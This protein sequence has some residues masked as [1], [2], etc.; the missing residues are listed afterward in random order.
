MARVQ[1]NCTGCVPIDASIIEVYTQLISTE[2]RAEEAAERA[3]H[4]AEHA[5]GKSPYIGENGDWWE[6]NDEQAAFIDTGVQ[7]QGQVA[8]DIEM[9]TTSTNPVQNRVVTAA[10]NE[11]YT[12]PATGIPATDIAEGVIPD[13]SQFITASVNN[14]VNYYLKSETYNKTEVD[15]LI[16]AVSQFSYEVV[17]TLPTASASTM[18]KIYLVPSARPETQN[19]KDEYITIRS[20]SVGSYTY[21]WEQIGSTAIDLSGYVTTQQLN[22]A[23]SAYTTTAN[24][25]TLLAAKQD[26]IADLATIRS[27]AA[28]GATAYQKPSG[29]IPKS[30]LASGVQGSLDLADSAIQARPQGEITPVI[31]PADYATREELGELEA[32]LYELGL[33]L[34]P[35]LKKVTYK[36]DN[37]QTYIDAIEFL[38]GNDELQ[39]ISAV[40]TQPGTIYEGEPLED[41][42]DG[43]VVTAHYT[44]GYEV[45]VTG[46]ELSGS[47]TEGTSTVT[48]TYQEKT[49][50]FNV[51]VTDA[52]Y[53]KDGSLFPGQVG[54]R[55]S[56]DT[57]AG[58]ASSYVMGG[59]AYVFSSAYAKG[60]A[61]ST[62]KR[63]SYFLF[64]LLVTS[65]KTYK[66]IV[67]LNNSLSSSQNIQASVGYYDETYRVAGVANAYQTQDYA[68][69]Q[70]ASSWLA[71]TKDGDA[72]YFNE[73][74][75]TGYVGIRITLKYLSSGTEA[76]WPTTLSV[77]RLIVQEVTE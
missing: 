40:Y 11:K 10:V 57:T 31:T 70:Q 29:G 49:T 19:V 15:S 60:G 16:S 67:E 55:N 63:C 38:L 6:W 77:K 26:V 35:L 51:V 52:V 50:T 47:L 14:L 58:L 75:P 42:E 8:V 2:S 44:S 37:A 22:T 54:L 20:G 21:A 23:L 33:Y 13:V 1:H 17:A 41:L 71:T 43:L 36:D 7:A 5:I 64:D 53:Y 39:S 66:Y 32:E 62:Q 74:A 12:K 59:V 3:E 68:S 69:H 61:S 73:T 34:V 65:G 18:Y 76:N 25:A 48:V 72:V 24:L 27:G 28:S 56:I 46:Y 45:E 9:S 4:A 30:D